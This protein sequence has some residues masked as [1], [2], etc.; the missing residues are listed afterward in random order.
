VARIDL[1][2][3]ALDAD[4]DDSALSPAERARAA[5]FVFDV[6]RRR[7]S[8]ARAALRRILA[9]HLGTTPAAIVFTEL[10]HGKPAVAGLEFN[11]SHSDELAVIAVTRDAPL[12]VD[13]ERVRDVPDAL[14]IAEH[15]FAPGERAALAA[16]PAAERARA[17]LRCWTRKEAFIKAIGEGLSH[18][19]Q[20]FE[21]ALDAARF[22][23]IDGSE[24]A[25]AR[26]SLVALEPAPGYIGAL[27]VPAT[28]AE[29]TWH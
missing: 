4:L 15:Y 2:A 23:A 10:A 24:A 21:V 27:A 1:Y 8:A 3:V 6:H 14:A 18:P 17:F 11:L 22:I 26:W 20:R 16:A 9:A 28:P 5:R 29:I 13:V 25:A 7:F 12:G 19:L